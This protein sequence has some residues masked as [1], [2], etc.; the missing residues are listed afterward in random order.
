MDIAEQLLEGKEPCR[1]CPDGDK[2]Y[3]A[4]FRMYDNHP[5]GFRPNLLSEELFDTI[6][7]QEG[8]AATD[9]DGNPPYAIGCDTW[10]EAWEI[11]MK[12]ALTISERTGHGP[13][14]DTASSS[15]T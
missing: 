13:S 10:E 2:V 1:Y 8:L 5:P 12:A 3:F 7:E 9:E 14:D 15:A 4:W 6:R 11:A